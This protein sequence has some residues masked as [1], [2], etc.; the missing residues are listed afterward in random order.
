MACRDVKRVTEE[1]SQ[2]YKQM[3]E[4]FELP[5]FT[6]YQFDQNLTAEVYV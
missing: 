2:N 4:D 3:L 1:I 6:N 5:R